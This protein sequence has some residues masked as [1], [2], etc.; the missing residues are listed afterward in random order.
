MNVNSTRF[1]VAHLGDLKISNSKYNDGMLNSDYQTTNFKIDLTDMCLFSID[2]NNEKNVSSLHIMS[3]KSK[4]K[5]YY[6]P[7]VAEKIIFNTNAEIN[8]DYIKEFVNNKKLDFAERTFKETHVRSLLSKQS[9]LRVLFT[10]KDMCKITISKPQLEQI[11]KTL[12]S[13]I[14]KQATEAVLTPISEENPHAL[15]FEHYTDSDFNPFQLNLEAF[16]KINKFEVCFLADVEHANQEIATLLLD[17]FNIFVCKYEH[18]LTFVDI[19]LNDVNL[20][21][22]LVHTK[23]TADADLGNFIF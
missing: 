3:P 10:V 12:D 7:R 9:C 5:L 20:V 22:K 17:Q 6:Q 8:L 16:F 21:D 1:L 11:N 15:N 13:L 14:Y 18:A 2:S 19:T 23:T 4:F